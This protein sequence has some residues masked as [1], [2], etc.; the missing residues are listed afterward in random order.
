MAICVFDVFEDGRCTV[1][2]DDAL[3]GA[4]VYRWW[5]FD[6]AEPELPLW[7]ASRLPEIP[8]QALLQSETR[9]RCDAFDEGLMLNLRGINL[10]E[11]QEA[12]QMVSIRIWATADVVVTVR[13]RRVFAID[14][15]RQRMIANEAPQSPA[16]FLEA[17]S[18]RLIFRIQ[19]HVMTVSRLT[20]FYEA[21]L[22]DESTP[23]PKELPGTRRSVIKLLRYLAPQ[24]SAMA[25]LAATEQA[26]IPQ[27]DALKLRELAN[28]TTLAVEELD[29]LQDRLSA[30]QEEHD[31][32]TGRKQARHG[33]IL[34]VAAGVF[35]PLGFL[36]GL[37]G[38]NVAGMP[39]MENPMAFAILCLLLVGMGIGMALIMKWMR[40]L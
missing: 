25:A 36:T 23:T 3:T 22:E 12:D 34:S 1:P 26:M 6:L 27:P 31:L 11:G 9:P 32:N 20:E 5:H 37:F 7:L 2:V 30:V 4:G 39:G 16:A 40:W 29:A 24:Q 33:Y 38:V 19:E 18:A 13:M 14:E 28:R 17:L 21:D 15:L 10:N 8:A 35:L